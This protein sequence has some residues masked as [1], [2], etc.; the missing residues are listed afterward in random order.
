MARLMLGCRAVVVL[1]LAGSAAAGCTGHDPYRPGDSIGV[2]HVSGK[3]VSTSCGTTPDP[4]EFDV[5]LRHDAAILYWVQ[6]DAPISGQLD[7]TARAVLKS[8]AVQ[9]VRAADA[10]TKTAAC[11]MAR[12]DVLDLALAPVATPAGDVGGA[13]SFKGTLTYRF[14]VTDGS[15][16]EDQVAESGGDFK[17]LPCDV[18]Y[19]L[20]GTRTGDAK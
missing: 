16:C 15:S 19:D 17:T 9:T 14:T 7:A 4:W 6:G 2:F 18:Q 20:A 3:L 12:S 1:A 8:T 13:T 5:R 11:T 10:K